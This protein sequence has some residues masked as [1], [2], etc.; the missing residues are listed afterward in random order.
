VTDYDVVRDYVLSFCEK[1][2]VRSVAID[3]W[4]ATHLTTQLVNEGVDVKPYGQGYASL[5]A[6]TKMLEAL[7][8]G[9]RIRH[10]GNPPLALHISNMQVK[11]DDAG[12]IKPTKAQSHSTARIDAAV[13]LI[14]PLGVLA[15]VAHGPEEEPNILLI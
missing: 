15:G 11:Q 3:R 8:L 14:M 12:N 7:V 13:A 10:G 9:A 1:N 2:V 4:N 6:P 5:S